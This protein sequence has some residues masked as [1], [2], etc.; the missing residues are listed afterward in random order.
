MLALVGNDF[1]DSR[2]ALLVEA[3][4]ISNSIAVQLDVPTAPIRA[5]AI[6]IKELE[7]IGYYPFQS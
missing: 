2:A 5:N 1:D 4:I 6:A 7:T 3:S